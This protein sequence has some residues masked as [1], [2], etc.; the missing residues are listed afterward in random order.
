MKADELSEEVARLTAPVDLQIMDEL[1]ESRQKFRFVDLMRTIG[2]QGK[3]IEE[4]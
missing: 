4:L 3:R 2:E 1:L